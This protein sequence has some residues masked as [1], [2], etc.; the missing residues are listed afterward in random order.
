NP[1]FDNPYILTAGH[2]Q[3]QI[4]SFNVTENAVF[5]TLSENG[6]STSLFKYSLGQ[7]PLKIDFPFSAGE[8]QLTT[9]SP[10][11]K[12]IWATLTGWTTNNKTYLVDPSG[13][14]RAEELGKS[15]DYP[16][17]KNVM[18]E[19]VEVPSE[20]GTLVPLSIIRRRDH[21]FNAT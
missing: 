15:P 21:K 2:S 19:V 17:F 5:Y 7:E 6:I 8:I 3:T 4:G 11:K 16:E 1:N 9:R 18:T 20:D 10:Y 12:D 13:E 14:I